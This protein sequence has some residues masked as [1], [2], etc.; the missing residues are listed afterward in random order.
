MEA[1]NPSTHTKK[2][3]KMRNSCKVLLPKRRTS[4]TITDCTKLYMCIFTQIYTAI[5]LYAPPTSS[6]TVKEREKKT[7]K[8]ASVHRDPTLFSPMK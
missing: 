7:L 4:G 6:L 2:G 8:I 1:S 3:V 5:H